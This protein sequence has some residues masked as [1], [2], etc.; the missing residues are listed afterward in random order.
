MKSYKRFASIL[1]AV[2]MVTSGTSAL[3]SI[4]ANAAEATQAVSAT[5]E[6]SKKV[7][8]AYEEGG[9]TVS[10]VDI[11]MNALGEASLERSTDVAGNYC[12][13]GVVKNIAFPKKGYAALIKDS[14]GNYLNSYISLALSVPKTYSSKDAYLEPAVMDVEFKISK[15]DPYDVTYTATSKLNY[16]KFALKTNDPT[17]HRLA[18]C[19]YD[20]KPKTPDFELANYYLDESGNTKLVNGKDFTISY[21]DN[22]NAGTATAI[23]TGIGKYSGTI[24]QTFVIGKAQQVIKVTTVGTEFKDG[25][26]IPLKVTAIGN[27]TFMSKDESIATVSSTGVLYPKKS[28]KAVIVVTASGDNNYNSASTEVNIYVHGATP[29]PTPDPE[30]TVLKGDVNQDGAVTVNDVTLVQQALAGFV[31]LNNDQLN[32][33]DVTG[34]MKINVNDCT[35]IQNYLAG[36]IEKF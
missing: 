13:S 1:L 21:K 27:V 22:V 5:S 33:A 3:S 16:T 15:S 10:I 19:E 26:P 23:I 35:R 28:G 9:I 36:F 6:N 12:Y 17:A 34:D 32:A 30:P 14:K 7:D 29:G 11:N 24:S 18:A 4:T 2:M 20:G 31:T 8:D 25:D